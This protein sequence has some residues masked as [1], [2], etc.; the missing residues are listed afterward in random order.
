MRPPGLG[1]PRYTV[2]GVRISLF[3]GNRVVVLEPKWASRP[4][5]GEG[6]AWCGLAAAVGPRFTL[7]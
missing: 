5:K 7:R 2:E 1:L 6:R 4:A 3:I